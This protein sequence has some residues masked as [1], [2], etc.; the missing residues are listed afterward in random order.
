[1]KKFLIVAIVLFVVYMLYSRK[2]ETKAPQASKPAELDP[3]I[4]AQPATLDTSI[5]MVP[6]VNW[7]AFGPT[8]IV[9]EG[10][11]QVQASGLTPQTHN[12][13]SPVIF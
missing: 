13:A 5:H 6:N 10:A 4:V 9:Q 7:G 11:Q 12:S 1:M 8:V 3:Q 2:A